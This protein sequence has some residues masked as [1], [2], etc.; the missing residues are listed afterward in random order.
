MDN[1]FTATGLV[2]NPQGLVLMVL[3]KKLAGLAAARRACGSE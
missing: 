2:F 1:H 3:H